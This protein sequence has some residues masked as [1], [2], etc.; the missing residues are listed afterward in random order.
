MF[1]LIL[2][3]ALLPVVAFPTVEASAER[4]PPL[5]TP[6][7][8]PGRILRR[9]LSAHNQNDP[10]AMEE[11]VRTSFSPASLAGMDVG[12]SVAWYL[13]ARGMFG[14]LHPRPILI[15]ESS[16]HRLVAHY[17]SVEVAHQDPPDPAKVIVVEVDVDPDDGTHLARGLGLGSLVCERRKED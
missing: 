14:E 6:D 15:L 12:R 11:W 1:R 8:T 3:C 2:L 5:V 17:P 10:E 7:T 4:P 9:W 16:A 13:Q